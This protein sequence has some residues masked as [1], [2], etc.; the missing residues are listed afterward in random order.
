[1]KN[2]E[3]EFQEVDIENID[4]VAEYLQQLVCACML[5]YTNC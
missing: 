4:I 2:D 5:I 1:M 3:A